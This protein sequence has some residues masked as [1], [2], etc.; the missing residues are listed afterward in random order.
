VAKFDASWKEL[1]DTIKNE[2]ATTGSKPGVTA[3]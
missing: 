3:Q 2:M 1:L